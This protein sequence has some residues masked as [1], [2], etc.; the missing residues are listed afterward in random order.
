MFDWA[1]GLR[2]R[3]VLLVMTALL[4]VFGLFAYSA[5]QSQASAL[6][7][8]RTNLQAEV[9]IA[10]ARQ[11]QLV[12]RVK[13]LLSD[14][15]SGPSVQDTR[16]NCVPYLKNLKS[17]DANYLN[18]GVVGLDGVV[19]CIA[20]D[21]NLH[22]PL[23]WGD[24][25][26]FKRVLAT[27]KFSVGDYAVG[28]ISNRPSLPFAA[29]VYDV[30][31]TLGGVAFASIDLLE[32]NKAL[33]Y[34]PLVAGAHL[35]V[36]DRHGVVLA[37]FPERP[38]LVG[39]QERDAIVLEATKTQQLDALD[40]PD[41]MGV[42]RFYAFAPVAGT[43]GGMVVGVSVP[44]AVVAQGPTNVLL[45]DLFA[46]LA[47]TVLGLGLAWWLGGRLI[48]RPANAILKETN[49]I[50]LGNLAAR[51][52]LQ[53]LQRG[54]LGEIGAAF[55]RMAASLEARKQA[56][57]TALS[58]LNQERATRDLIIN[59]MGE[60][61]VA[62]DANGRCLFF[63]T[64]FSH[65]FPGSVLGQSLDSVRQNPHVMTLDG[66]AVHRLSD[67]PMTQALRGVHV[68]NWDALLRKPGAE[69]RTLRINAR[70]LRDADN[71][72]VGG[73]SVV[74][75]ITDLKAAESFV[76]GQ[77]A[78]LSLIA[79]GALLALCLE[80]IVA[81]VERCISGSL[82][83]LLLVREGR[84]YLGA[85]INLPQSLLAPLEGLAIGDGVGACGTAAFLKRT[86]VVENTATDPLM[87]DF[88]TLLQTHDLQACW[89]VPVLSADNEIIATLALYHHQCCTPQPHDL[90][91]LD[92]A[93]RLAGIAL[94]RDRA[95]AALV[96][97]EARFRELA[98]NIADV[99]YNRDVRTGQLLYAS[100]GYEK[101]WGRSCESLYAAPDSYLDAVLPED[102][103]Q[104]IR[105]RKRNRKNE[106]SDEEYRILNAQGD[107]RWIR[108][109]SYPVFDASGELERIVGTAQ[110]ITDRKLTELA[111]ASTNRALQMLSL[112]NLALTRLDDETAL[113]TEVCRVAVDTGNYRMAWVGYAQD[114][115]MRSIEPI[116]HAGHEAGYLTAIKLSWSADQAIGQ[117]PA[118]RVIR[119]GQP[120]HRGDIARSDK[121]FYWHEVALARGYRSAVFL[122]LRDEQRTFGVLGLYAS[123]VQNFP[124]AEVKLLQELADN[125]AFGIGSLRA[126]LERRRSQE[127]AREASAKVREQASLL[128]RAQ[129]AIMVRNLDRTI[130]YWNKGAEHLYGWTAEEVMGLTMDELMYPSSQAFEAAMHHTLDSGGDW[131]GELEQRA[132]DGSTVYVE[133]RWTAVRDESGHINGMLG[134]NTD[135]CER[136]RA[137]EEI[138]HLNASLEERVNQ[139]TA[140]L[141]FA[142]KQLEAFSYSLSHDLRTPLSAVDG[143]SH[144]LE[145]A[146]LNTDDKIPVARSRHYLARIRAG[147][148]QMGELIDVML[149]LAQVSRKRLLWEPVDLSEQALALLRNYQEHAPNRTA[150]LR[151][152]PGLMAQGDPRLLRQ[153]LDNLLGNAWKFSGKQVCAEIS[154]GLEAIEGTPEMAYVV[155]DNGAGFDMAY[156]SKL[157]GAF[158]RLHSPSEFAGTGIGLATVQRIVL[159]HGGRVWGHANP[160]AGATF[161]FTLNAVQ[162]SA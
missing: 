65:L 25:N 107:I 116:A 29:P 95:R 68:D 136:R 54:E 76:Q 86:V 2:F 110:D 117:G 87:Q 30:E 69:E 15:A 4:P 152:Q 36:L 88:R 150:V 106:K 103:P 6:K 16:L 28:A 51:I 63:N 32:I 139:R 94:D 122:P 131:S 80:A 53:R 40:A 66:S 31:G 156:A 34:V 78:V 19:K 145:K 38:E 35:R 132:R 55:N 111:L 59:S 33:A 158:E 154:F 104:Q 143:F 72:L 121:S 112:S 93:A 155:R 85:A 128:D 141:Q 144:L 142:N 52:D 101:I 134:I 49:E 41:S 46:L 109:T 119:S 120:Q 12:D 114:N 71:R 7:L 5:A 125:L 102:E 140:Q 60:G 58:A 137:R 57:E 157:F 50:T 56:V 97:S 129:D 123:D 37:T 11:A 153:V 91:V 160:G 3:L 74:S 67:R 8:A 130:R 42:E 43:L 17:Q 81:L 77:H 127:A 10:A 1:A 9:L 105:L 147:V 83:S 124:E 159:R 96:S 22:N 98:E 115:P 151:V 82:C 45:F 79:T 148:V 135:I 21:A 39:L 18:L 62:A 99:F 84:L 90:E 23:K 113:L 26:Y 75:D 149:S 108:D 61:V 138:M 133:A 48:V 24:R 47:L 118:G 44:L 100:P 161:Y 70:P 13:Q 73:V 27:K 89:S 146:V 20:L 64:P 92:T 162:P 14:M 126:R